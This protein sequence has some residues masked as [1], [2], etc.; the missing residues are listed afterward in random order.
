[1]L[2]G[3]RQAA[4]QALASFRRSGVW[5]Q[6]GLDAA[7]RKEKLD[8]RD[9]ALAQRICR[10]VLRNRDFLDYHISRHLTKSKEKLEPQL[11]DILR[12]SAYELLFLD[13]VPVN[14]SVSQ[15]VELTKKYGN[16][17][18]AG[19]ANAVLRRIAEERGRLP[20]IRLETA[21]D[22]LALRYSH[23]KW[24]VEQFLSRMDAA[25][26]EALLQANNTEPPVTLQTNPIKT[27][28]DALQAELAD[29]NAEPHPWC[30]GAF[31]LKGQGALSQ[32]SALKEGC[33]WVQDA[34]ARTAVFAA[35]VKPGMTVLDL[36]AAPGGKSFAA[37]A[38][39][40]NRGDIRAFDIGEKKLARMD[41]TA[42]TLGISILRT[43]PMDGTKHRA[44]LD[45]IADVVIAD[46][47]CSG[48]GTMRKSPD[49]RYKTDAATAGLP[50]IQLAILKNAGDY[51]KP[52]GVL[53]Y[54]TCTLLQ[55]EN[56]AVVQAFLNERSDY[57]LEAF[58]LPG[59]DAPEGMKT[60]WPH[61][62][63]TDGFFAAKL[64]RE[65]THGTN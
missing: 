45:G 32:V 38:D 23:P 8:S 37:A 14:A 46:V 25:E 9:A 2:S 7:I 10:G 62:D 20:E 27:T 24:L 61:R 36:C 49:V 57:R 1:M 52:G 56:E 55:R 63:K 60:F 6:D 39:M 65:E 50:E 4:F 5:P 17:R 42:Q 26:C 12:L 53:L 44:V 43:A 21:A 35:G 30:H 3:G 54:S 59:A 13:R 22:T 41:E 40:E 34:A 51:V 18:A 15:G 48:F 47:P 11:L 19:L 58:S 28:A 33:A 16:P 31:F 64:R 29:L